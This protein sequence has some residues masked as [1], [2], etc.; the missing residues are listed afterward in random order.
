MFFYFFAGQ[1]AQAQT[2][3]RGVAHNKHTLNSVP[4]R[5]DTGSKKCN[6]NDA[7]VFYSST[8]IDDVEKVMNEELTHI[9]RYCDAN[10]LSININKTKFI[11]ITSSKKRVRKI[12]LIRN[13][14][15]KNCIKYLGVYIDNNISWDQQITHV[16]NKIAKNTGIITKLRYYVD[17]KMLKQLLTLI[18]SI[19]TLI[20][21]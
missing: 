6:C 3:D 4:Q 14:E 2:F 7:N 21:A 12:K 8:I 17:L 18:S 19:R 1:L 20:T 11:V 9:F 15:Q 5:T 16:N 13:I 10:K